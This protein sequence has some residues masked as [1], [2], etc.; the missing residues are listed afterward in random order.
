MFAELGAGVVVNDVNVKAAQAVCDEIT[1]SKSSDWLINKRGA[2]D[3]I[4]SPPVEG[5]KA[6]PAVASAED[7]AFIIKTALDAPFNKAK[8]VDVLIANAGI[9]RDK[10]FQ[11]MTESDWDQVIAVHLRGT[12][13]CAK[14]VWALMQKQKGGRIVTTCSGVGICESQN[15]HAR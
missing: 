8:R 13:K 6:V 12:F 9:L 3:Y 1:K 11:A 5:G 7:S 14:D 15:V 4:I 10:S 2:D